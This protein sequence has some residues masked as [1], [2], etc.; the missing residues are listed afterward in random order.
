MNLLRIQ[1]FI[2]T[3]NCK[4]F[5]GAAQKNFVSQPVIS[6]QIAAME[7][8]L[9]FALF[10]REGGRAHLTP[11]GESFYRDC[12]CIMEMYG[13]GVK[14]ARRIHGEGCSVVTVGLS[15][16]ADMEALYHIIEHF[17][18]VCSHAMIRPVQDNYD[19]LRE[20]LKA[21]ELDVAMTLGYDF[22][23]DGKFCVD[24]LC[25]CK[26]GL[27]VSRD[28]PLANQKEVD[29]RTLAGEKIVAISPE[30]GQ[31]SYQH[32]INERRKEGYVPNVVET[33][34]STEFLMLLVEMNHGVAFQPMESTFYNPKRCKMLRLTNTEDSPE[35]VIAYRSENL[36]K[37]VEKFIDA[38]KAYFRQKVQENEAAQ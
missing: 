5:T 19:G 8:E 6:Q 27:L 23:M 24:F 34:D 20:R 26:V 4:S 10:T 33:A 12:I 18:S 7:K 37:N 29:A 2:D 16:G 30:Y 25:H 14:K 31:Q 21:G 17:K 1:Y 9:D 3:V 13:Q 22:E 11:A 35:Y 15:T 32:M 36:D 38:A 28:H